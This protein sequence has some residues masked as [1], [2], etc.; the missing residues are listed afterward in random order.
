MSVATASAQPPAGLDAE[1]RREASGLRRACCRN[2]PEA[3]SAPPHRT[4]IASRGR[5]ACRSTMRSM[6]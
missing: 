4:A 6:S 5:V 1:R 2:A 3:A